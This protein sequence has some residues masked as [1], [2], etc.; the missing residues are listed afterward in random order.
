MFE[1]KFLRVEQAPLD[2]K[3]KF[4]ETQSL[5]SGLQEESV[6][7][8]SENN[9]FRSIDFKINF[10]LGLKEHASQKLIGIAILK[11]TRDLDLASIF[12]VSVEVQEHVQLELMKNLSKFTFEIFPSYNQEIQISGGKYLNEQV[13]QIEGFNIDKKKS[14]DQPWVYQKNFHEYWNFDFLRNSDLHVISNDAG[15]AFQIS[16][17]INELSLSGTASLN[18]P[19]VKI[20]SDRNPR[21]I[22]VEPTLNELG[23][24]TLLFGSGFF[25]GVESMLLESIGSMNNSKVVLLDH[26]MNFKERF[27]PTNPILPNILLTTNELAHQKALSAFPDVHVTRIPDFLLAEY[28]REFD[29][30]SRSPFTLLLILEPDAGRGEGLRFPIG[31]LDKYLKVLVSFARSNE[32]SSIVIRRH[33]SQAAED[34]DNHAYAI[35]GINVEYSSSDSLI[36]DIQNASAVFGFHSYA[37]YASAMLGVETFSFFAFNKDHW[38][39]WYP[40]IKGTAPIEIL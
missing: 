27:N 40:E 16:A 26:W 17:L 18:G 35:S 10:L 29:L 30:L 23:N 31:N 12:S 5:F 13:L 7:S 6:E 21:I 14:I 36:G 22:R 3:M 2:L 38:T 8:N 33:P 34:L 15:G 9:V 4:I 28:K 20:F 19:A 32:I 24:K 39:Y 25:G 37:L 11:I 1:V